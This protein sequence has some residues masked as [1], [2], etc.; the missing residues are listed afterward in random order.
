[1]KITW[2]SDLRNKVCE[3]SCYAVIPALCTLPS[4]KRSPLAWNK[5]RLWMGRKEQ[6]LSLGKPL[7]SNCVYNSGRVS[8][9]EFRY[10]EFCL[11]PQ[12]VSDSSG[13]ITS[14]CIWTQTKWSFS[15]ISRQTD[16]DSFVF[17]SGSKKQN[18]Q[19]KN[20]DLLKV[21]NGIVVSISWEGW[22][23]KE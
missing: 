5:G 21:G 3:V 17:I 8:G 4:E 15:G 12:M 23:G 18:K 6:I 16:N 13:F 22:R 2:R 9:T 19:N 14:A 11:R 10:P 7:V 1:M 20:L